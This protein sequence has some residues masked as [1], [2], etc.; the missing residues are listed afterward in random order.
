MPWSAVLH[1]RDLESEEYLAIIISPRMTILC[2]SLTEVWHTLWSSPEQTANH[3][4]LDT[5]TFQ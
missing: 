5:H 1:S 3:L 4:Q 2:S